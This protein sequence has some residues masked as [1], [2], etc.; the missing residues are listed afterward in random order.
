MEIVTPKQ[1]FAHKCEK[2]DKSFSQKWALT[3]HN[4]CVHEGKTFPCDKCDIQFL[5][6]EYL[7]IHQKT[8]GYKNGENHMCIKCAI[9]SCTKSTP[10]MHLFG[11]IK[12]IDSNAEQNTVVPKEQEIPVQKSAPENEDESIQEKVSQKSECFNCGKKFQSNPEKWRSLP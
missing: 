12:K 9:K 11:H 5:N 3:R 8:T 7:Q 10:V 1:S 6:M 2:C 4:I